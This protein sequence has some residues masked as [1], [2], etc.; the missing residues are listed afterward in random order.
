MQ[1]CAQR[2]DNATPAWALGWP[3][4]DDRTNTQKSQAPGYGFI[5]GRDDGV[6]VRRI[7]CCCRRQHAR[8]RAPKVPP[9]LNARETR[10]KATI[11][12]AR[13]PAE[14]GEARNQPRESLGEGAFRVQPCAGDSKTNNKGEV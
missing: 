12:S 2:Y 7:G 10:P 8:P 14:R 1:P 9:P 11:E 5:L 4:S 6:P 13:E 3:K